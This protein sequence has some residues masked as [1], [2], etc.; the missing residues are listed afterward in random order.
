M[1]NKKK[2]AMNK[3]DKFLEMIGRIRIDNAL[4]YDYSN[5]NYIDNT[6]KITIGC[7][8]HGYFEQRPADH[9]ANS[10]CPKCG[11]IKASETNLI[12]YGTTN[13]ASSDIIK[14]KIRNIFIEKYE[15]ID[16]PSKVKSIKD[17]K[18]VT[19]MKNYGVSN[20]SQAA[21]IQYRKKVT[22][23]EKYGYEHP[24]QNISIS[25]KATATKVANG[26]FTKSNSSKEATMYIRQYIVTNG[27]NIDQCAYADHDR[28]LHEW[29]TYKNGRWILYDL[30]VFEPGYRGDES[31]IIEILEYHGP[32]HYNVTD[33]ELRG[34][35]RAYPWK[36]NET[37]ITESYDRDMEKERI[38]KSMTT[39]YTVSWS[40]KYGDI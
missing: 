30:V 18:E 5:V 8:I 25:T 1:I 10:G 17:K 7:P 38:G 37:T 32:F 31:K 22:N 27:Y 2:G 11:K 34:N 13:P 23:M 16:N 40:E 9:R 39:K 36:S 12:K 3:T 29:G 35:E 4:L 14:N 33:T 6:T 15:G 26:G 20:P 28:G 21:S 19:C 24:M